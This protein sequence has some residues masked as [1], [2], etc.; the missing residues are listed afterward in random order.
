MKQNAFIHIGPHKTAST[1]V[2]ARLL[3]NAHRLSELGYFYSLPPN[4]GPGH[5]SIANALF[6]GDNQS[7]CDLF[8]DASSISCKGGVILSSENLSNLSVG[9][10]GEVLKL[11][12]EAYHVHLVYA[13]RPALEQLRSL[14]QEKLKAGDPLT[15]SCA[16]DWMQLL[17][18]NDLSCLY[19]RDLIALSHDI[20]A[21][22]HCM[23]ITGDK[24]NDPYLQ[25]LGVMGL[26]EHEIKSLDNEIDMSVG[27]NISVKALTQLQLSWVNR[28]LHNSNVSISI[29]VRERI[30]IANLMHRGFL[31]GLAK[32]SPE[33]M[34]LRRLQ[35]ELEQFANELIAPP[36]EIASLC[37]SSDSF[38]EAVLR[39]FIQPC[40]L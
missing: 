40:S 29:S 32:G 20:G 11:I 10:L 7:F 12:P 6:A 8:C 1:Y 34:S 17:V 15:H 35:A 14:F 9:Q 21:T 31:P 23:E 37:S 13:F 27:S 26:S 3:H 16:S 38:K 30:R 2:Q 24:A 5:A 39:P 36:P 25:F 19:V 28:L 33:E 18:S 4:L 22:F